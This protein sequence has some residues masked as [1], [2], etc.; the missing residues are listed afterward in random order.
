MFKAYLWLHPFPVSKLMPAHG[1]RIHVGYHTGISKWSFI[2]YHFT[3]GGTII[4]PTLL[5]VRALL[6]LLCLLL[7][8]ASCRP[9]SPPAAMTTLLHVQQYLCRMYLGRPWSAVYYYVLLL[10]VMAKNHFQLQKI[11]P[12]YEVVHS[13]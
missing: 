3:R 6:V 13:T 9:D 11:V 7:A 8:A 12:K 1:G 10:Q 5:R 4:L 2:V